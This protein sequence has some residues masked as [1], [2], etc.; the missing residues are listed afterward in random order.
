MIKFLIDVPDTVPLGSH[1]FS[2]SVTQHAHSS[3]NYICAPSTLFS[4]ISVY[5]FDVCRQHLYSAT[6]LL[7][8]NK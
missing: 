2:F 8:V 3:C 6:S 7:D 4:Y 5:F 1:F